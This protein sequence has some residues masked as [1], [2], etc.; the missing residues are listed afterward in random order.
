MR[1]GRFLAGLR[2]HRIDAALR[3]VRLPSR[4]M[5]GAGAVQPFPG[6]STLNSS[7]RSTILSQPGHSGGR[8]GGP[9]A[10]PGR[11]R[12]PR[13]ISGSGRLLATPPAP[14]PT[15]GYRRR[16]ANRSRPSRTSSNG[17][18][19]STSRS[20]PRAV[21]HD[22]ARGAVDGSLSGAA[23]GA[24]IAA[25]KYLCTNTARSVTETAL[26]AAGGFSLTC[27]LPLERY[28]RDAR[29]GLFQPPQDDLAP[30]HRRARRL[31]RRRR[32]IAEARLRDQALRAKPL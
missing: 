22:M 31:G 24:Q 11:C 8:C 21:L 23:L 32:V 20:A 27:A 29:G 26:R 16:S 14:M 9:A 1:D 19:R 12:S 17:S 13:S 10:V 7:L 5:R 30:R 28:F 2:A 4:K 15:A 6:S 18:A 3:R 25:A